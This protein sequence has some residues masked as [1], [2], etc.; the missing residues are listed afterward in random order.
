ME[1]V[2]RKM[3]MKRWEMPF[4]WCIKWLCDDHMIGESLW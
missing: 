3:G 1:D 2:A 4:M